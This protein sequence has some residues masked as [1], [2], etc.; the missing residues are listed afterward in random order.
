[1]SAAIYRSLTPLIPNF[2]LRKLGNFWAPF[3]GAGIK[4][5]YVSDD[6]KNIHVEMPLK[7]FNKNY[8]GTHF[9]GSLYSMT[10]PFYMLMLINILGDDYIVW[11]KEAHVKFKR[12]G[13]GKV[14]AKFRI[15]DEDINQIKTVLMEEKSF[16]F[17]KAVEVIDEDGVVICEAL[18]T[19]FI[20]KRE[21]KPRIVR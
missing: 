18:K 12:P 2:L 20:K 5:S 14:R 19:I 8:V 16:D 9:G 4:I 13:R 7:W 17:K 11:D 1:M 6:F 10:D 15:S 21:I 3:L